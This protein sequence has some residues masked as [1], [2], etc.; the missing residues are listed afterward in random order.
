MSTKNENQGEIIDC[1]QEQLEEAFVEWTRGNIFITV[2][3]YRRM[4]SLENPTDAIALYSHLI[5]TARLQ[6]TNQVWANDTYL[7]I[8]LKWG[9]KRLKQAK[10]ALKKLDLIE[11]I[12]RRDNSTQQYK[13]TY[14]RIKYIVSEKYWE[15]SAKPRI[16]S[17]RA[18][19]TLDGPA[20]SRPTG[21]ETQ[22]LKEENKMLIESSNELSDCQ[23]TSD[24]SPLLGISKEESD[25][26][27]VLYE[28]KY[29]KREWGLTN[30]HILIPSTEYP[31]RIIMKA[32]PKIK[33]H[34]RWEGE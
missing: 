28:G 6:K 32:I 17:R 9:W 11:Y 25:Y 4:L 22:M 27:F 26:R 19:G 10:A 24:E 33:G 16:S 5:F 34:E 1:Y 21:F 14:I 18:G 7:R 29:Y 31:G 8:G 12:Q 30:D 23:E 20:A 13:K 2:V 3:T 15:S